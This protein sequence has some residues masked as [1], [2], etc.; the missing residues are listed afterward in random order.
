MNEATFVVGGYNIDEGINESQDF[1]ETLALLKAYAEKRVGPGR[2]EAKPQSGEDLF[3]ANE[4][5]DVSM[6]AMDGAA[7]KNVM[8]VR[9]ARFGKT[10]VAVTADTSP[11]AGQ[12]GDELLTGLA[13]PWITIAKMV[14]DKAK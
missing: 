9:L 8:L 10:V 3:G 7:V 1:T 4:A 11:K 14:S 2:Y 6:V 13:L 12:F 5:Y